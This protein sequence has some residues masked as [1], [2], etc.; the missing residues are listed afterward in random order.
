MLDIYGK[1]TEMLAQ[2]ESGANETE[3]VIRTKPSKA[4]FF[5]LLQKTNVNRLNI[6]PGIFQTVPKKVLNALKS[7][8]IAIEIIEKK[9]GRPAKFGSEKKLQA[10]RMI[11]EGRS[12]RKIS[13]HLGVPTTSIYAWKRRAART[14]AQIPDS[15]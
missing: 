11:K 2:I 14:H 9:A 4:V 5:H 12:A 10:L 6:T 15:T 13:E 1:R 8:G 7:S 3:A